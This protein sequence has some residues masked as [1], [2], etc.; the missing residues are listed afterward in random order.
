[1]PSFYNGVQM[2]WDEAKKFMNH[3]QELEK[4]VEFLK[5]RNKDL[6]QKTWI[7]VYDENL[8]LNQQLEKYKYATIENCALRKEIEHL[9][10]CNQRHFDLKVKYYNQ[11]KILME[12]NK[13]LKDVIASVQEFTKQFT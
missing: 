10:E 1:M 2:S 9:K 7:Q 4:Q 13:R 3:C 12:E 5:Q 11:S 8:K 6:R